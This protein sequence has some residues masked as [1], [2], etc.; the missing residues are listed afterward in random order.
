M[1]YSSIEGMIRQ[2]TNNPMH[3]DIILDIKKHCEFLLQ[4]TEKIQG[5]HVSELQLCKL[6]L[7]RI[8]DEVNNNISVGNFRN[9]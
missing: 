2:S 7:D 4:N 3:N 8:S 1:N 6:N 5:V 9:E